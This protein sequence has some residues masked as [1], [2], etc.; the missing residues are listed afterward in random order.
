MN[1][2]ISLVKER[3]LIIFC[4]LTIALTYAATL[5]PLPAEAIPVVMVFIPALMS[6]F[7]TAL[8]EGKS[9]V[10]ALLGKL[11]R[12][13]I[14]LKWVAIAVLLGFAM[15]MLIGLIAVLLGYI[16]AIQLRIMPPAQFVILAVV[17]FIFAI[18]EELG[19]RGYAMPKLLENRSPLFVGILV[20][21]LWGS[22]HLAL[23]LPGL[24]YDDLPP[25]A[26]LF[27]LIGLSV[28][29]AWLYIHTN[30]NILLTSLF[31]AAQSFFVVLNDGIPPT[32]QAWLMAGA[33][34]AMAV[35]VVVAARPSFRQKPVA[36][37]F[38]ASQTILTDQ[39]LTQK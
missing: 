8:T 3:A 39:P 9:G 31:H 29:I 36:G 1:T 25:L 20:G 28:V 5:L 23:H 38:Q 35:I 14:S 27:Q 37:I 10:R 7:L 19:W 12:W 16:P 2:F 22:L 11:T 32:Q 21:V 17:V 18:P 24:M 34:L 13:R 33:Y 15:R 6:I 30:G 26:T 4:A